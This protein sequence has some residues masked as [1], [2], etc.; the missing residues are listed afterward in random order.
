MATPFVQG[1]LR[2]ETLSVTIETVCAQSGKEII[3]DLDSDGKWT[4]TPTEASPLLFERDMNWKEFNK[5]N[6]I[7]DY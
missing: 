4:V 3:I 5:P 1:R 7:D 6:I 2:E